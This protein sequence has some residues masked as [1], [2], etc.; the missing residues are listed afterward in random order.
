VGVVNASTVCVLAQPWPRFD[1]RVTSVANTQ[2][3]TF[4]ATATG[5][6][7]AP[8][9]MDV[10]APVFQSAVGY[11]TDGSG[12]AGLINRVV[13]TFNEA[14]NPA[15]GAPLNKWTLHNAPN[16]AVITAVAIFNHTAT[17]TLSA[18]G[19]P[20]V[21]TTAG[22]TIDLQADPNGVRDGAGNQASFTGKPVLDGMAPTIVSATTSDSNGDAKI[23]Q[24]QL[25]LSEPIDSNPLD[26]NLFT[27]TA[28]TSWGGIPVT[29]VAA[30]GGPTTVRLSLNPGSFP[31]DTAASGLAVAMAASPNGVRDAT[32][33]HNFASWPTT[34]VGDGAP[35]V[36]L[37]ATSLDVPHG[38]DLDHVLAV[39]SEPLQPS[40]NT[41][42][43]S[44]TQ[45]TGWLG[46]PSVGAVNVTGPQATLDIKPQLI[47]SGSPDVPYDT[48]AAI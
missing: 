28:P 16:A 43:W 33:T 35:P 8:G 19:S 17:L 40:T 9:A 27:M 13:V 11:N 32:P 29:V 5:R 47:G 7:A 4:T 1:L 26:N 12:A 14:L 15:Y 31:Q 38:G 24:V 30:A 39:F 41:G 20:I 37:S 2:S 22:F 36:L 42:Q 10:T 21:T 25:T 18:S 34:P 44:F 3:Y 23:D 46:H 45:P 6:T 48:A